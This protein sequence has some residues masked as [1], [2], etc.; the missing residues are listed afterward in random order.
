MIRI[1]MLAAAL[2]LLTAC[3]DGGEQDAPS[4]ETV[5]ACCAYRTCQIRGGCSTSCWLYD[6][7][8]AELE[9]RFD[10]CDVVASRI[11]GVV[12]A[13]YR[14]TTG[15]CALPCDAYMDCGADG[16]HCSTVME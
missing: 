9:A 10:A 2:A 11:S 1:T 4:P 3:G 6:G 5:S 13:D 16:A 8:P 15:D 7:P 12:S 14:R